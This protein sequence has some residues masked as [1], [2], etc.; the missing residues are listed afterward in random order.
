MTT[1]RMFPASPLG[2]TD[3]LSKMPTTRDER[4]RR[5]AAGG[6]ELDYS[7]P[8]PDGLPLA[9]TC[10]AAGCGQVL[11]RWST[12]HH[13]ANGK[14]CPGSW[15]AAKP[16]A[17]AVDGTA[18]VEGAWY[19]DSENRRLLVSVIDPFDRR[20]RQVRGLIT[21]PDLETADYATTLPIFE[22][23]WRPA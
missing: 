16:K 15:P 8:S 22:R 9:E 7:D 13:G 1:E 17:K 23:I 20:D 18:P 3:A 6:H 12:V 5:R 19:V 4:E 14:P 11:G 2:A 10:S 21:Y